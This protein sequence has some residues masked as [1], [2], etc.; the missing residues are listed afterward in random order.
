MNAN[1]LCNIAA[2]VSNKPEGGLFQH[3]DPKDV[4]SVFVTAAFATT[5]DILSPI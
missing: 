1:P 4:W 3:Y 5:E 2:S